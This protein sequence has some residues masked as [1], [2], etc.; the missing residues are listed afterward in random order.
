MNCVLDHAEGLHRSL[1]SRDWRK[2]PAPRH[3]HQA[4]S[5]LRGRM[6]RTV[7]QRAPSFKLTIAGKVY[8]AHQHDT[9]AL[10]SVTLPLSERRW[11]DSF[12]AWY[13]VAIWGSG[14][15]ATKI[16]LQYAAPFT[17]LTLRFVFGIA[18]LLPIVL[19]ARPRWPASRADLE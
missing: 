8:S 11:F 19:I 1:Y 3:V 13:F 16:G 17:F 2:K 12:L 9:Q 6:T 4:I 18:C 10:A 5:S 14:F 15:L 7:P